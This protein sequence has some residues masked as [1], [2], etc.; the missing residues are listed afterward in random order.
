MVRDA[1]MPVFM[2]DTL[3]ESTTGSEGAPQFLLST[4]TEAFVAHGVARKVEPASTSLD[5]AVRDV[6]QELPREGRRKT[7]LAQIDRASPPD[8]VVGIVPSAGRRPALLYRPRSLVRGPRIAPGFSE[9]PR[10]LARE[11][12]LI[13]PEPSREEYMRQVAAAL[14]RIGEAAELGALTKVVLARTLTLRS[15]GERFDPRAITTRLHRDPSV[16]VFSVML[17]SRPGDPS[18]VFLGAT[19]ELLIAKEGIRVVSHPLAGSARRYRD[20][21]EDKLSAESLLRSE[22]DRREHAAAVES[23]IERLGPFCRRLNTSGDPHLVS[24]AT[25]WHLATRIDILPHIF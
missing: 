2:D 24:T 20:R 16:T 8:V 7:M 13:E 4:P 10:T 17:P 12:L 1:I 11:S 14:E 9:S 19:P 15:A 6:L 21:A 23:I 22:K 5:E 3:T 25:M 18:R